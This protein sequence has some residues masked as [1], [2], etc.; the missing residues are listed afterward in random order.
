VKD[1]ALLQLLAQYKT[2][3]DAQIAL[4]QQLEGTASRQHQT[5]ETRDFE[6][7]AAESDRR[8]RLTQSLL[9][10]EDG[11]ATVRATLAQSRTDVESSTEF[12]D[13]MVLRKTAAELV[14]RILATDRESMRVLSD[15][16]LAR[17]AAIASL[18]R[19]ETTLAA[20]RKV[21]APPVANATL[22]DRRG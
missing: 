22:L 21:L 3:L 11:L 13:V 6:Q 14:A 2:A 12:A 10:I 20:Y 19:G 16:E 1:P 8:D 5:T 15:A 18:E 9:A 17:R 7:L 4:L